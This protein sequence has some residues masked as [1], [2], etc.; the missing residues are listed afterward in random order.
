MNVFEEMVQSLDQRDTIGKDFYVSFEDDNGNIAFVPKP[1]DPTD[2]YLGLFK[3]NLT[4]LPGC[5]Y[6]RAAQRHSALL[7]RT[8]ALSLST[9]HRGSLVCHRAT[10]LCPALTLRIGISMRPFCMT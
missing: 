4:S 5:K 10:Q 2:P 6:R 1:N 3:V 8:P 9:K 7:P